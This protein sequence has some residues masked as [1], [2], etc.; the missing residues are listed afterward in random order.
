MFSITLTPPP[1]PTRN[2]NTSYW[3]P[4]PPAMKTR[5]TLTSHAGL[6][7]L[8]LPT[9][10]SD[11]NYKFH[12]FIFL[13][14][15]HKLTHRYTECTPCRCDTKSISN[16]LELQ[17]YASGLQN[18]E[19]RPNYFTESTTERNEVLRMLANIIEKPYIGMMV[20]A[21]PT[22]TS[23]ESVFTALMSKLPAC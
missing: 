7:L 11:A 6:C 8:I 21:R 1:P 9:Y 12:L 10:S 14:T 3:P 2:E 18:P 16:S 22:D 20:R 15:E 13:L 17:F 4:P 23:D 19:L 5:P